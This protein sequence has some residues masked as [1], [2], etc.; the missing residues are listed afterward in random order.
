MQSLFGVR[1]MHRAPSTGSSHFVNIATIFFVRDCRPKETVISHFQ[2][3]K[4]DITRNQKGNEWNESS[5]IEKWV[6]KISYFSLAFISVRL[7]SDCIRLLQFARCCRRSSGI[8]GRAVPSVYLTL[9]LVIHL[10]VGF[11]T[12]VLPS[13]LHS[14]REMHHIPNAN[15]MKCNSLAS[16]QRRKNKQK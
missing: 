3:S 5:P 6:K 1:I 14:S 16:F 7:T 8:V 12:A 13:G 2:R 4:I 11:P 10:F 15:R 9:I